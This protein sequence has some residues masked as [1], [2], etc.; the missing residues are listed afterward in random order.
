MRL[1]M[2]HDHVNAYVTALRDR[3]RSRRYTLRVRVVVFVI[4]LRR[5]VVETSPRKRNGT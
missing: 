2:Y 3:D 4:A 5:R 1:R